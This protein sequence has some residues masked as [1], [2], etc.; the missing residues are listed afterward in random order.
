M[1]FIDI[2]AVISLSYG[3]GTWEENAKLLLENSVATKNRIITTREDVYDSMLAL[4]F[5]KE[6]AYMIT[7]IVRQGKAKRGYSEKW[8]YFRQ[9]MLKAGAEEW[10]VWSLE[11]I[12]YLFSRACAYRYALNS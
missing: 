11:Q 7:K 10:F 6:D 8:R 4:G 12:T 5:E 9:K 1:N 2:V 3:V